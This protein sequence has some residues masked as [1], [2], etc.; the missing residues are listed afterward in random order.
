MKDINLN[1]NKFSLLVGQYY[2]YTEGLVD[3]C[4]YVFKESFEGHELKI[5]IEKFITSIFAHKEFLYNLLTNVNFLNAQSSI[6]YLVSTYFINK[7]YNKQSI[8]KEYTYLLGKCVNYEIN[9][10][11][12]IE[13]KEK[14]QQC[15]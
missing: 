8:E 13:E 9:K 1:Y 2:Q 11:K 5:L 7:L 15:D 10:M 14:F 3:Q 6:S 12:S 4:K